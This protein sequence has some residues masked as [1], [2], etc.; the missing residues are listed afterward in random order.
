M[1]TRNSY[2]LAITRPGFLFRTT[3]AWSDLSETHHGQARPL[4]SKCW[5]TNLIVPASSL[6]RTSGYSLFL[7]LTTRAAVVIG[8]AK[9][10]KRLRFANSWPIALNH[11]RWDLA[12]FM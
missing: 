10:S 7:I 11:R 6:S 4:P 8:Y 3:A 5:R 12:R 9:S 2:A 1:A